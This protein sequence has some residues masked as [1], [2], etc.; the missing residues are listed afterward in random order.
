MPKHV[1]ALSVLFGVHDIPPLYQPQK[2]LLIG[3]RLIWLTRQKLTAI[4]N[5]QHKHESRPW[6]QVTKLLL[7]LLCMCL[8]CHKFNASS[9]ANSSPDAKAMI[10]SNASDLEPQLAEQSPNKGIITDQG[11]W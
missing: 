5:F 8:T 9:K 7:Y 11:S 10:S 2:L 6:S 4:L 1:A 3:A